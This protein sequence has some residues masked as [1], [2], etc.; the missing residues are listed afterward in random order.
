[1]SLGVIEHGFLRERNG[2]LTTIDVPGSTV[3]E[4]LAINPAGTL[5]GDFNTSAV[6]FQGFLRSADGTFTTT[7][8]PGRSIGA[9]H[10]PE[11]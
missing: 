5:I 3:T 11:A 9:G 1:L 7:D 4:V 10:R 2:T 6:S 8:F